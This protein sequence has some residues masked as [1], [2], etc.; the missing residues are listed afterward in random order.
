MTIEEKFEILFER[1]YVK[2]FP[3]L[4]EK[5]KKLEPMLEFIASKQ[6][7]TYPHDYCFFATIFADQLWRSHRY[8][9]DVRACEFNGESGRQ[10]YFLEDHDRTIIDMT[11]SQFKEYNGHLNNGIIR[12]NLRVLYEDRLDTGGIIP[13]YGRMSPDEL[14]L[15]MLRYADEYLISIGK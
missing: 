11:A 5:C 9:Y 14:L 1:L 8:E 15:Q 3:T 13:N 12:S 4:S 7:K 10:H 6:N 2:K